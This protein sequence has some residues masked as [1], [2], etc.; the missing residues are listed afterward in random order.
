MWRA[1][2]SVVG[3]GSL[4]ATLG[5]RRSPQHQRRKEKTASAANDLRTLLST[6]RVG[7]DPHLTRHRL[8]RFLSWCIDSQIPELL[9]LAATIDEWWPEINTF[10]QTGITNARTEG[11]NRL[12]QTGQTCRMRF[13]KSRQFSTPDT[14]PLHPQTAGRDPDFMLI[15]RSKSKSRDKGVAENC[16]HARLAVRILARTVHSPQ[17]KR[18]RRYS[19]HFG[20]RLPQLR[21]PRS[22]ATNLRPPSGMP[23]AMSWARSI[24]SRPSDARA[25]NGSSMPRRAGPAMG[26]RC[27]CQ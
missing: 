9:T 8:H 7:G 1:S 6:V 15:A 2:R 16:D 24:C 27:H 11:Y 25:S 19:I 17:R 23:G 10:V 3:N 4:V 14:I 22:A 5:S 20:Q 18:D 13:P 26:R 12:S 21:G